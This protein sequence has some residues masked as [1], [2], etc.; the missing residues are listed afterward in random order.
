MSEKLA[1]E[2]CRPAILACLRQYAD[3]DLALIPA[4]QLLLAEQ[5]QDAYPVFF[6]ILTNLEL[7][8][9]EAEATWGR[10][11]AHWEGTCGILKRR[12]NLRTAICDYFCSINK[13]LRNPKLIELQLFEQIDTLSKYDNLTN[14][15]NRHY[16][17]DVLNR[18]LARADRHKTALSLLLIDLDDFKQVNDV[19]GHLA[20]D[21]VL[22]HIARIMFEEKR[23]EDIAARLGGDE[24]AI[25]LP[26]TDKTSVLVVAKRIRQRVEATPMVYNGQTIQLTLSGGVASFPQDGANGKDLLRKTDRA[27]YQAKAAGKNTIS[28]YSD[29][30]R[31]HQRIDFNKALE[32]EVLGPAP[33]ATMPVM[34]KNLSAG[35]LLLASKTA[36]DLGVKIQLGLPINPSMPLL[37][38]GKVVRIAAYGPDSYDLGI[39]FLPARRQAAAG[40]DAF[41]RQAR[42]TTNPPGS[43]LDL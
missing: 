18:E 22:Q 20:G 15:L 4:L 29:N 11:I 36:L 12:I 16:F 28:V 2:T 23:T 24:L 38:T 26:E 5:G 34:G 40:I 43:A 14:L 35:G 3:D 31:R 33:M 27:L 9:D 39:A 32:L 42:T 1:M 13:R 30:R 21:K 6:H 37:V 25:I 19:H 17:D 41:V 10:I 8:P 7:A